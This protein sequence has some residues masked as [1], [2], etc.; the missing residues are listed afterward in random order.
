MKKIIILF[1]LP[2]IVGCCENKQ[3]PAQLSRTSQ[4]DIATAVNQLIK[5]M[6]TTDE[7]LLN[8]ILADELVYGHSSGKV[9]NKSEF[10]A[11][12]LSGEPLRYISIEP[13]DQKIQ[14]A[15][16]VAVVRHIF[17]AET[18]NVDGEP[19]SLKIGNMMVW[20]LQ[21]EHWKLLARQAY[22]L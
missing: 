4:E 18:K 17:T 22:R 1:L 9:Q 11:E 15:G 16:N 8:S 12:I 10:I 20:H 21:I 13:L 5:A 3:Q 7:N 2:I 14:L 19:G 6:V